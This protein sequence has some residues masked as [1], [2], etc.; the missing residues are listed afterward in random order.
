MYIQ[1]VAKGLALLW[2]K[3]Y[4]NLWTFLQSKLQS[5]E[6]WHILLWVATKCNKFEHFSFLR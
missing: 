3:N 6:K 4:Q 5:V 1:S 2:T